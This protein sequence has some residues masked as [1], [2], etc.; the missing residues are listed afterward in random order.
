MPKIQWVIILVNKWFCCINSPLWF[1]IWCLFFNSNPSCWCMKEKHFQE[2][3]VFSSNFFYANFIQ[4]KLSYRGFSV[5]NNLRRYTLNAPTKNS[6]HMFIEVI[7]YS[8]SISLLFIY[9]LDFLRIILGSWWSHI[10][11]KFFVEIAL[12][13]FTYEQIANNKITYKYQN[14]LLQKLLNLY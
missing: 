4:F 6:H 2:I 9:H 7:L 5:M 13:H 14:I 1:L 11:A 10:Y 3:L 8:F 12:Q